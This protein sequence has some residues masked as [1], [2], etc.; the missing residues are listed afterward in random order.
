MVALKGPE[1]GL[2]QSSVLPE[3]RRDVEEGREWNVNLSPYHGAD[4]GQNR[5]ELMFTEEAVA[6]S[7]LT[8]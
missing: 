5:P 3:D 1:L 8:M 4:K 6:G 7:T 2:E